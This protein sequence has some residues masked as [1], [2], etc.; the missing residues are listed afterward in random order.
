V[1]GLKEQRRNQPSKQASSCQIS[2]VKG[3]S[4]LQRAPFFDMILSA[5]P[6]I[7]HV[8]GDNGLCLAVA[9]FLFF[10]FPFAIAVPP[11]FLCL[12]F[13]YLT[14][15]LFRKGVDLPHESRIR[16]SKLLGSRASHR[17]DKAAAANR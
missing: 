6:D 4:Q 3:S 14:L 13:V 2:G 11:P 7:M 16:S 17:T 5:P 12:N 1:F 8:G 9:V 15:R 10:S